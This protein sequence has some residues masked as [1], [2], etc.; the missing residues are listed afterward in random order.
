MTDRWCGFKSLI[1]LLLTFCILYKV[2]LS[3]VNSLCA[4]FVPIAVALKLLYIYE[5]VCGAL[6]GQ[7]IECLPWHPLNESFSEMVKRNGDLHVLVL[8]IA[9]AV[10]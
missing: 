9:I 10:S 3:H 7:N 5:T 1:L 8:G 4:R 2:K 6:R